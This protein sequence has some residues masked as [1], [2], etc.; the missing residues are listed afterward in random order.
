[1]PGR[2]C[3]GPPVLSPDDRRR[4]AG[5]AQLLAAASVG[6]D[7][8]EAAVAVTVGAVRSRGAPFNPPPA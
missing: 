6:Y 4:L 7:L 8:L 2:D 1:M 3:P 5:E